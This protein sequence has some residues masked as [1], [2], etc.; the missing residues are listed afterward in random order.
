MNPIPNLLY[1][2]TLKYHFKGFQF[3]WSPVR[4][5]TT[6][7]LCTVKAGLM[8]KLFIQFLFL[9]LL[10]E[11]KVTRINFAGHS[12]HSWTEVKWMTPHDFNPT[13]FLLRHQVTSYFSK[14]TLRSMTSL[15]VFWIRQMILLRVRV[16]CQPGQN[17]R[18]HRVFVIKVGEIS[19][20]LSWRILY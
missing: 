3:L 19:L 18:V 20:L 13:S 14:R 11:P 17:S 7:I 6:N 8:Y 15:K 9:K 2:L 10:S 4:E 16:V 12:L 1:V 5:R